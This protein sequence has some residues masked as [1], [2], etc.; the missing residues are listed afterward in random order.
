MAATLLRTPPSGKISLVARAALNGNLLLNAQQEL[1]IYKNGTL[2]RNMAWASHTGGAVM[3]L[4]I[5]DSANGTD[6]YGV[7]V[8]LATVGSTRTVMGGTYL[9]YFSGYWFSA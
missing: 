9:T 6:T 1:A 4:T 7:W 8:K 2:Y 5:D 3:E